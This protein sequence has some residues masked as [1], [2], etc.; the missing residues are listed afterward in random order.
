M[1]TNCIQLDIAKSY[2]L[3]IELRIAC[4]LLCLASRFIFITAW[5]K[6]QD[7]LPFSP[8]SVNG[9]D[10]WVSKFS[11]KKFGGNFSSWPCVRIFNNLPGEF[12]LDRIF[13][14]ETKFFFQ[15]FNSEFS[16]LV[17]FSNKIFSWLSHP[18]YEIVHS[19][20]CIFS[21]FIEE[22]LYQPCIWIKNWQILIVIVEYAIS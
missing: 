19:L 6:L 8:F 15:P 12:F 5:W 7:K 14:R 4:Q 16:R 2:F 3:Y 10:V 18:L 11:K 13:Q 22:W 20:F 9:I 17:N 1:S 21:E